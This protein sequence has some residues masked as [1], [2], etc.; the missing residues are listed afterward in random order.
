MS[1]TRGLLADVVPSSAVDGPGNRYVVF[2]QG[3]SFDCLACHNPQTICRRATPRSRWV[4]VE[5]LV[6]EIGDAAPF[7]SGVTV[8]GGEATM[9]WEFVH[10]LFRRLGAHPA[11]SHLTFL[12]DTNG[13]AEPFVWELLAPVMDGAMVDLKAIDP[14]VHRYLTGHGNERVLA[15]L[16]H[17]DR[18]D[19]LTEVR[20]L[21]VPGVNDRSDHV[22][23]TAD[24]LAS[25]SVPPPVKVLAF[26][27]D[28]TREVARRFA[29]ATPHDVD[30]VAAVLEA[31][32][33][34]VQR[35][36]STSAR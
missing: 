25:L 20:L 28:G 1:S 34:D 21:I 6:A 2:L 12:V 30:A 22:A 13:D 29:E 14:E 3:C 33:L 8:S 10:E 17:L 4:D 11:T 7:L 15:A 18:L 31:R 9:Q 19:R 16:R 35:P 24:L 23:A 5:S 36:A 26:R 27:H 32:G